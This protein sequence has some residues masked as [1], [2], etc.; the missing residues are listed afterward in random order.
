MNVSFDFNW[1]SI[2]KIKVPFKYKMLLWNACHEIFP[3]AEGLHRKLDFISPM[4]SR[5]TIVVETDI[6]LFRDCGDSSILWNYIFSIL[7]PHHKINLQN[8][9]NLDWKDWI[10]FNLKQWYAWSI[11]FCVALRHLWKAR[12]RAVFDHK[13]LKSF[14]VYN[15]FYVDLIATNKSLQGKGKE[16]VRR[17]I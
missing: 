4:C 17:K 13:M 11:I 2:W 16:K 7:L 15:T 8:F 9:F 14:S 3:V 10:V 6:H 5:C 12:N 1:N